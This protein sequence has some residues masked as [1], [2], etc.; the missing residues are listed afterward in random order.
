M[1]ENI[2]IPP[3]ADH[4]ILTEFVD[5]TMSALEEFEGIVLAF[6]SGQIT[7]DNFV[8]TARRILHSVKGE[9]GIMDFTEISNVCHQAESLLYGNCKTV[10]VD[11]LLSVKDWLSRAIQYLTSVNAELP[12][13]I[14]R[15]QSAK[16]LDS[17]E[18]D[19][20]DLGHG[21]SDAQAVQ[22]L[23]SKWLKSPS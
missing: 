8:T 16:I 2:H 5:S 23:S 22:A 7:R 14:F 1:P 3:D 9:S 19:L 11:I 10:P 18:I 13:Y 12:E 17:A 4:E 20:F 21:T 15:T 6:E